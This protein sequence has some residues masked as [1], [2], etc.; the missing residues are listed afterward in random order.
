MSHPPNGLQRLF[1]EVCEQERLYDGDLTDIR[2]TIP[3]SPIGGWYLLNYAVLGDLEKEYV[4]RVVIDKGLIVRLPKFPQS[5]NS[6]G[7]SEAGEMQ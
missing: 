5:R 3:G 7:V 6:L 1:N 4:P 2:V